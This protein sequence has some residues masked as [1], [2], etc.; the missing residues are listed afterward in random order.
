MECF[1]EAA[2]NAGAS[3]FRWPGPHGKNR[4]TAYLCLKSNA[5]AVN[6]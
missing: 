5:I 6:P 1:A 2:M 4:C 3:G